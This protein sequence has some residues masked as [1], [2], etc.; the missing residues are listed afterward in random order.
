MLA[1]ATLL[2]AFGIVLASVLFAGLLV[3]LFPR[4]FV[5]VVR[6]RRRV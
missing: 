3:V 5:A 1:V 6:L 4:L 2:I